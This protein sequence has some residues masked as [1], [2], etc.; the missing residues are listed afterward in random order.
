M[1]C[2]GTCYGTCA[3]AAGGGKGAGGEGEVGAGDVGEG[4]HEAAE[5]WVCMG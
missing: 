2:A 5:V 3:K 1:M 4:R